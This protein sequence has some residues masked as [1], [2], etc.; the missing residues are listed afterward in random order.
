MNSIYIHENQGIQLFK[1]VCSKSWNNIIINNNI[2]LNFISIT[3]HLTLFEFQASPH[4]V[5]TPRL[6]NTALKHATLSNFFF[7]LFF[8]NVLLNLILPKL[9]SCR[10]LRAN[11]SLWSFLYDVTSI[12]YLSLLRITITG[13]NHKLMREGN[14]QSPST[15]LETD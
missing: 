8:H 12:Y 4:G 15:A 3:R 2:F 9:K 1:I 10:A 5:A 7:C 11:S 13:R 6:K 14:G